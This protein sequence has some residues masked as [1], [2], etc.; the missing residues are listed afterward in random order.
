VVQELFQIKGGIRGGVFE[1]ERNLGVAEAEFGGKAVGGRT[2]VAKR[3]FNRAA[4]RNTDAIEIAGNTGFVFREL[5]ANLG[6]SLLFGIVQTQALSIARVER[7]DGGL[8]GADKESGVAFAMR[9]SGLHGSGVG[10]FL[11]RVSVRRLRV[12][13]IERL[14][15]TAGAN[16][17]DVA[18]GENGTEP[19]SE[20]AAAVEIA[21]EGAF[22][23]RAVRKSVEFSEERI[24]QIAG[25]RRCRAAAENG[26]SGSAK[27]GSVGADEMVPRGL[28]IFH[29]GGGEGEIFQ[30]EGG[31]ILVDFFGSEVSADQP[32]LRTA[33]ER[34]RESFEGQTPAVCLGL[35]VKRF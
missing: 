20:G 26:G 1:T 7:G 30:M 35:G 14:K 5:A 17:V 31:E 28:A 15:A 3:F 13:G 11:K 29:A 33:L 32:F 23:A 9:V 2:A 8:Q 10:N 18:L 6:E 21:K 27:I 16:C 24:R 12:I 34:G 4:K 19:G 22:S 25:F